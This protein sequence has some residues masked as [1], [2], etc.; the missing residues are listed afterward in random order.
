MAPIDE[1]T[2]AEAARPHTA[3]FQ[4]HEEDHLFG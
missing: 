1:S 3:L 2:L 4:I